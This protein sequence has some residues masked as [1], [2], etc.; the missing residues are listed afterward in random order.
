MEEKQKKYNITPID[1]QIIEKECFSIHQ[2]P[3][4]DLS[5]HIDLPRLANNLVINGSVTLKGL[6]FPFFSSPF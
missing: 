6:D 1:T 3:L 5:C 2:K 4:E